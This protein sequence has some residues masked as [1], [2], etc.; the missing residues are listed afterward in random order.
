[1][2]IYINELKI[3]LL[4]TIIAFLFNIIISYYY[5]DVII[6]FILKPILKYNDHFIYTKIIEIFYLYL[7]IILINSVILTIPI[8]FLESVLFLSSGLY[9]SEIISI[10]NYIT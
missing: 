10:K 3:R 8:I 4:Y 9:K 2:K 1:M 6:F 7:E 5:I